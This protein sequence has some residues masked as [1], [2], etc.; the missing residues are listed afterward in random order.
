MTMALHVRE[1]RH[2]KGG[3]TVLAIPQLSLSGPGLVALVGHNGAGKTTLLRL[4]SGVLERPTEGTVNCTVEPLSVVMVDQS[5]YLFTCTV[6]ANVSYGLKVR[7]VPRWA[8]AERVRAAL[9]EV[10]MGGFESR[11]ARE[12]SGGEQRRVAVA[13]ALAVN[14]RILLLDEPDAGLDAEA[15]A[16]L[17]TLIAG[18]G[19]RRLVVFST[20]DR[21]RAERLAGRTVY[22]EKGRL[23]RLMGTKVTRRLE[24]LPKT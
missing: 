7:G 8:R 23:V 16:G 11:R 13:R 3:R 6:A 22:L 21:M 5:P 12:L 17:E 10:G 18:L 19:D 4:L 14:P 15:A 9:D 2:D 20:H 1:L 24:P